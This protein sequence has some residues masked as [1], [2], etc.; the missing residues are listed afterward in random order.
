VA[1][2][3]LAKRLGEDSAEIES[4]HA[5]TA[6]AFRDKLWDAETGFFY[7]YDLRNE[8]RIRIRTCSGL[9]PL[10]AGICTTAQAAALAEHVI[11]SF[12]R[13]E[14]WR[15]CASTAVDDPAFDPRKYWRGP[16]WLSTNWML[17]HGLSRYGYVELAE[18]VKRDSLDLYRTFGPY[19]YFDPRPA[20][21]EGE[22]TG[23]GA[24]RFSW[25][26][27]LALDLLD[28]AAPL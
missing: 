2:I 21:E 17:V 20:G 6:A 11:K 19:E 5:K 10:F 7:A 28:N 12:T 1:L 25:S 18:R 23:Y 3:A 27:A 4:W 22:A 16:V 9:M 13:G 24:D 26:A 8:R 14:K 15:L